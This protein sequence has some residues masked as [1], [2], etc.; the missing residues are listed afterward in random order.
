MDN[1][2]PSSIP[3]LATAYE[4]ATR[5]RDAASAKLS[6]YIAIHGSHGENGLLHIDLATLVLELQKAK[7]AADLAFNNLVLA[8]SVFIGVYDATKQTS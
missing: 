2:A 8:S 3:A 5:V 4:R 7:D 1:A 6:S